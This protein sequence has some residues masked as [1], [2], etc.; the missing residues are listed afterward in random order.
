LKTQVLTANRMYYIHALHQKYGP[1]VRVSPNEVA[2]ADIKANR[3]I[4]KIGTTFTKSAWYQ[5]QS[6]TQI[7]DETC[8]VFGVR[9]HRK[10]MQ[11]RKLYQQAGTKATVVQWEPQI[12][13]IVEETVS[14]IRRD[15]LGKGRVDIMR[16]WMMMTADVLGSLAFGE[17]FDIVKTESVST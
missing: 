4:H 6:P 1:F 12:R 9:D 13:S 8:G 10:A 5:N 3:E 14:K 17:P 16:W 11:R 2:V 7:S 15:A